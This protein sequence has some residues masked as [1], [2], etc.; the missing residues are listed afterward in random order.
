MALSELNLKKLYQTK[1]VDIV[2][3]MMAP[4]LKESIHYDLG[5]GYFSLGSLAELA[6]GLVPYIKHGG[7]VRVVTSVELSEEDARIFHNG[8]QLQESDVIA[9]IK[10]KVNDSVPDENALLQLDVITNLIAAGRI[11]LKVAYMPD[12]LYHE[13]IGFFSDAEGNSIYFSGSSNATVSGI[14]K[15]WENITVLASW[16]GD[17]ELI[18]EQQEYYEDLWADN[19]DE[20]KVISFPEAEKEDLL[21]KYKISPDFD[22]AA[23]KMLNG[24]RRGRKKKELYDYQKIAVSQFLDNDGRHFFEMATGTGK[25]FTAVKAIIKL[26]EKNENLSVVVLV[27]Q[28]DLQTQW[29]KAFSDENI[30]PLF[31]GGYANGTETEYNLS[32]FLINAFNDEEI[33]VVVSTYDTFFSKAYKRIAKMTSARLIVVDEAHNLSP[34]QISYLPKGFK[35]RLGLSATPERYNPNETDKIIDYFTGHKIETYKYTIE[36]AINAGYLSEY[37][38][39]PVF[40]HLSDE[41]FESYKNY[42]KQVMYALNEE[43]R[44][45]KKITDILTKRSSVVKKCNNKLLKLRDMVNG[46]CHQ[47]FDFKNSVVYC[48]HGKDYE[49]DD[50]IIDS[51]TRILAVDGKYTVSQFTSKTINRAQVL[52]E[53]ENE[54]YGTLVA[55]KCFDEGVDVPKLD[56]IYIM[57]SDA[58]KRQ[59]IQ[60]RGRVLRTCA[61]AGKKVAY[62]YDFVALPPES[63]FEGLGVRNLV[64]NEFKRAFEYAR[65]ARNK[66]DNSIILSEKMNAYGVAEEELE[67]EGETES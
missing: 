21:H 4:A 40:V 47:L 52:D 57:A 29:E 24:N 31:L 15:N 56:K 10:E 49:T 42:T 11:E 44:D 54:N 66:S 6:S 17:D 35:Y 60:R 13:K 41:D 43:P 28:I 20:L 16:W 9:K 67:D 27:P 32:T 23:Q 50:S 37:L 5:S 3:V 38:Y 63:V 25:T 65:L 7:N 46:R 2:E 48:G 59:T 58:L 61:E 36:E 64:I 12:G 45:Q 39:Y 53:F 51:L 19:V 1:K 18:A 33:N 22:T 34:K 55:I 30:S 26:A 14:R 62:I 8:L